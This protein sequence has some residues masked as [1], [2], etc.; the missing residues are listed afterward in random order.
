[1]D[2]VEYICNGVE[3]FCYDVDCAHA[4]VHDKYEHSTGKPCTEDGHCAGLDKP[5][6]CVMVS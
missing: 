1:M 5:V 4:N 2:E 6:K 3:K